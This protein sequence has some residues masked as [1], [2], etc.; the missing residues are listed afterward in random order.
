MNNA[1]RF[2]DKY[3]QH[4]ETVG[5][6]DPTGKTHM[7]SRSWAERIDFKCP[8]CQTLLS[9]QAWVLIDVQERP[10]LVRS[11]GSG[12]LNVVTCPKCT[13]N[14]TMDVPILLFSENA[15]PAM[16]FSPSRQTP[17][18]RESG[19]LRQLL[20]DLQT[21][22]ETMWITEFLPGGIGGVK[23]E[24]LA[25]VMGVDLKSIL[26]ELLELT[27]RQSHDWERIVHLSDR[28][29][30]ILDPEEDAP[31]WSL[32]RDFWAGAH[33]ELAARYIEQVSGERADNLER[34]IYHCRQALK[35]FT[36]KAKP[37]LWAVAQHNLAIAYLN[38]VAGDHEKNLQRAAIHHRRALEVYTFD[39]HP[40]DWALE[41]EGLANVYCEIFNKDRPKN[42]EEAIRLLTRT[43]DFHT[44]A[45]MPREYAGTMNNLSLVYLARIEGDPVQN[46][47][48]AKEILQDCLKVATREAFPFEWAGAQFNLA[49]TYRQLHLRH[50]EGRYAEQVIN[51]SQR[52]LEVFT[53]RLYPAR[54]RRCQLKLGAMHLE[55]GDL[56]Q[57]HSA[58][59]SAID[60]DRSLFNEAYTQLGRRTE[61]SELRDVYPLDAF[62][63]LRLGQPAEAFVRLEQ[64]KA[65][66]LTESLELQEM[67][68]LSLSETERQSIRIARQSVREL[69]AAHRTS[70]AAAASS[71]AI[72][73]SEALQRARLELNE[74]MAA[75]RAQH[76]GFMPSGLDLASL[77]SLAPA[78]GALVM[79]MIT[80]KGGAVLV[81]PH[82]ATIV[83]E[84]DH[85]VTLDDSIYHHLVHWM[86]GTSDPKAVLEKR[87]ADRQGWLPAYYRRRSN[88]DVWQEV[89]GY[90]GEVLWKWLI[91]PIHER[92]ADHGLKE[93]APV[94]FIAPGRLNPLPLHAAWR[95]VNGIKRYLMDDYT[96]SYGPS[97][98]ALQMSQK[99]L[100]ETKRQQ[101][102][103][104][105]VVNPMSDLTFASS[106]GEAVATMFTDFPRHSLPG[107]KATPVEV[108]RLAP[109]KTYLHFACHGYY[110]MQEALRSSL[111]LARGARLTLSEILSKMDLSASRLAVLSACETGLTDIGPSPDEFVG[112]P[113][114]FLQAGVPAVVSTLWAVND[115][116]TML[117]MERFYHL[118]LN[119]GQDLPKALRQAQIWLRDDVTA[120]GLKQRFQDEEEQALN[121]N[122]HLPM[123]L[124]SEYYKRFAKLDSEQRPYAHP[125]YWAAFNFCGA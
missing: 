96:V 99:R 45:D 50:G 113:A 25:A 120:G 19:Q 95:E 58:Y 30:Q 26:D 55:L 9:L 57:A 90:T 2:Y 67:D 94:L 64:G 81:L 4:V 20:S 89:I 79:P 6:L 86:F 66:L 40:K 33:V 123:E 8:E 21:R 88:P 109:G 5:V 11:I 18:D 108:L 115:L 59:A 60:A 44:A 87:T 114:G 124:A 111:I 91:G 48:R 49:E 70:Q 105:A 80:S 51:H 83:T 68:L 92:L 103:L 122:A 61:V 75:L 69:E 46:L 22:S 10:D 107:D 74:T 17:P 93:A 29:L 104:L 56:R 7:A 119:K 78:G 37:D 65:R 24:R 3:F 12:R 71:K 31:M 14:T 72:E 41:Q 34:T 112:L 63:L 43:L 1:Y 85:C 16:L 38:R 76:P 42:L 118:H 110:D 116:S 53:L 62:C 84:K 13:K 77:L 98:Y 82:G 39:S 121:G 100:Q 101:R 35:V 106:E 54:H 97:A 28:G 52:A 47:E 125:Y 15:N 117:L 23:R 102:S 27:R 32:I 73:L 36:R